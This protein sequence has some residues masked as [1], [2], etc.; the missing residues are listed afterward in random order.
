M[1]LFGRFYGGVERGGQ[2]EA[3]SG[4]EGEAEA[5]PGPCPGGADA[6]VLVELLQLRGRLRG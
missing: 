6:R 3:A 2:E 5:P 1:L 4:Q